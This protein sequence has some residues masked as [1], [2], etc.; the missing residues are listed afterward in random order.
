VFDS[1]PAKTIA[2]VSSARR[3][4]HQQLQ[5]RADQPAALRDA[6]AEHRDEHRAERREPGEVGD[7][8]GEDPVQPGMVSRLTGMSSLA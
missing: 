6:D 2:K 3:R 1:T 7:H 5:R 4:E 8:L